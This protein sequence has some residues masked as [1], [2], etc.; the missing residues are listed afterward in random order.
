M[1]HPAI[2]SPAPDFA[3]QSDRGALVRLSALRGR[4]VVI[5]FYPE[6]DSG[7]CTTQNLEFSA[8]VPKFRAAGAALFGISPDEAARHARFRDKYG[9]KVTLLADPDREAIGAYGLWQMKTL[10]GREFM[11]VVRMSF[12]IGAD[13][14]LVEAVRATRIKG[15]AER[16]LGLLRAHLEVGK[17]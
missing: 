8:L 11:G 1:A 13:G 10:Y 7:G 14:T 5:Y 15:H 4:P 6:D 3:L 9:L 12:L 17:S 16:M 2:G